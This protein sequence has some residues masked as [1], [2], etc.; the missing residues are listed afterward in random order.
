MKF[1]SKI[2]FLTSLTICPSIIK[3][4]ETKDALFGLAALT[5]IGTTCWAFYE[6]YNKNRKAKEIDKL[7]KI[8]SD[9][10][11]LVN[12]KID[13][14][15]LNKK[16]ML[17]FSFLKVSDMNQDKF[18]AFIAII[19]TKNQTV[20][21]TCQDLLTDIRFVCEYEGK[22]QL[23]FKNNID[24]QL[25][26]NLKQLKND[27]VN[28]EKFLNV[29]KYAFEFEILI[30]QLKIKY[31][32]EIG[33]ANS[34]SANYYQELE[35]LIK[36]KQNSLFPFVDYC[37]NLSNE[38]QQLKNLSNQTINYGIFTSQDSSWVI[39][40]LEYTLKNI[41]CWQR[42]EVEKKEKIEHEQKQKWLD[43]QI[44]E[45]EAQIENERKKVQA[46]LQKEKNKA[47]TLANQQA[48]LERQRHQLTVRERELAIELKRITDG[49]NVKDAVEKTKVEYQ[50]EIKKLQDELNRLRV[51]LGNNSTASD[52][53]RQEMERLKFKISSTLAAL[54]KLKRDANAMP[55]NPDSV[56][57]LSEYLSKLNSNFTHIE[58]V[59]AL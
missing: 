21:Q 32:Q 31:D 35:A 33:L 36:L 55:V 16:Y 51:A 39:S 45:K 34:N 3:T 6:R 57:G 17:E 44:K 46:K 25:L 23:K 2:L 58:N 48:D 59:L 50:K 30:R 1:N 56:D 15:N 53:V 41:L 20:K 40:A 13:I 11:F 28:Y 37:N 47:Q 26:S 29:G 8:I 7:E 18:K 5:T 27:L 38:L 42:Y 24:Q 49:Q 10:K 9:E 43:I 14:E 4:S 12:L 19:Q 22:I 54:A 52:S